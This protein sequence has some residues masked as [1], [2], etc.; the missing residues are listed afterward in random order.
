MKKKLIIALSV[1]MAVSLAVGTTLAYLTDKTTIANVFTV[2]NVNI[3]FEEIDFSKDGESAVPG[4][5]VAK[6]LLHIHP[7]ILRKING[8]I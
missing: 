1:V 4:V 5:A 7:R 3:E 2:G 6:Q 8:R